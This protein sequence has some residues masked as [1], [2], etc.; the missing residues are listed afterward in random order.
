MALRSLYSSLSVKVCLQGFYLDLIPI[1]R[2]IRQECP[3]LPLIFA[4][5]IETLAIVIR[6]DPDIPGVQWGNQTHKCALFADDFLLFITS[7]LISLPNV[8]RLL[9]QFGEISGLW[10]NDNKLVAKNVNLPLDLV[11]HLQAAFSFH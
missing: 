11:S 5:A 7:P 4:I 2:G 6:S 10:V 8:L 9:R 1:S 3:L